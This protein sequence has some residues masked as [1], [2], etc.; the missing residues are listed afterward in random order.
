MYRFETA[1]I[2]AAVNKINDSLSLFL[3][4]EVASSM[5]V[6]VIHNVHIVSDAECNRHHGVCITL[7]LSVLLLFVQWTLV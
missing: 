4:S 7:T 2:I 6:C 5:T 1:Q 3:S